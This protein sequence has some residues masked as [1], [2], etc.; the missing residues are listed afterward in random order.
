MIRWGILGAGNI[1]KRFTKSLSHS[2]EAYLYA[3]ASYTYEKRIQ[4]QNQYPT[5]CVYDQ[6]DALLDDPQVDIVYIATRH[7]DHYHWAKEALLR[8]KAVLCE[9]P[10]TL[11]YQQTKELCELAKANHTLFIEGIKTRF[12]PLIQDIKTIIQQQTIGDIMSIETCFAYDAPYREGHYLHDK[13]QGGILYDVSSYNLAFIFDFIDAEIAQINVQ[14]DFKD[15]VD[16]NDQIELIFESGQT[17]Y[18]DI[19]MNENKEKTMT[20]KGMKGSITAKPFYRPEKAVVSLLDQEDIIEKNYVYDDFYTEIQEA[21]RCYREHLYESSRM[22][23]DDSIK[24]IKT[25]ETIKEKM[26]GGH[27]DI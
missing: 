9:K 16:V 8:K 5:L 3:V 11:S 14:A 4:W 13:N 21:H 6:Y 25:I 26:I 17:A 19:A 23:L 22:S 1:A 20:I 7:K 2:Q 10:A 24:I 18:I 27:Y 12:I 15:G